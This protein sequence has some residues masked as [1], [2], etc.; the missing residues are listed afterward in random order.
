VPYPGCR[1]P[2]PLP[3][4]TITS[5]HLSTAPLHCRPGSRGRRRRAFHWPG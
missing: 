1:P 3:A 4:P 5:C 2:A